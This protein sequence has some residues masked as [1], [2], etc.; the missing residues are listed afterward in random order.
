MI[1]HPRC[2][3]PSHPPSSIK[4]W[5]KY[6][7]LL[8]IVVARQKKKKKKLQWRCFDTSSHDGKNTSTQR[9]CTKLRVKKNQLQLKSSGELTRTMR[10]GEGATML[11]EG[12]SGGGKP[13]RR[14]RYRWSEGVEYMLRVKGPLRETWSTRAAVVGLDEGMLRW[15]ETQMW[16]R[17]CRFWGMARQS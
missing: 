4:R 10:N 1:T 11:T 2:S 9:K 14:R 5:W 17:T 15:R 16:W 3:T 12:Y 8:V 7:A 6:W 13:R